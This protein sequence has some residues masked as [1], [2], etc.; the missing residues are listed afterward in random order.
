MSRTTSP[1]PACRPSA[2]LEKTKAPSTDTSKTPPE[3]GTRLTS[4]TGNASFTS[5]T[6]L[7]ALGS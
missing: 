7:V 2:F 3:D 6:R 5:A 1:C 4:A